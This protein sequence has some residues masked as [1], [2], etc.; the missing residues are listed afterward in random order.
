MRPLPLLLLPAALALASAGH[1]GSFTPPSG[2]TGWMTVQARACRVSNYYKC[3]GD[4]PGDQWRADFDQE[5]LFFASKIDR[6][7]QWVLSIDMNPM[8]RQT[9]DPGAAD[10]ASFDALLAGRDDFDFHLSRD[11]GTHSHV[12]GHD[13][14]TGRTVVIDHVPLQETEFSFRE[15]NEAGT[16]LRQSRGHEYVSAEWRTFFSGPSEWDDASGGGLCATRR[17]AHGVHLSGRAGLHE[18]AARVRVRRGAERG[19]RGPKPRRARR[20]APA[21]RGR[22]M[23]GGAAEGRCLCGAVRVRVARLASTMSACHCDMCRRWS[24]GGDDGG[25]RGCGGRGGERAGQGLRLLPL[26]GTGVVRRLRLGAL[27]PAHGARRRGPMS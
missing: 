23:S 22:A 19:A 1:A 6:Q 9:L 25:R 2:C 12:T 13:A 18:H 7:T 8:V 21:G 26:R 20:G 4:A 27:V 16:L 11:D 10:P 14:L 5:G 15:T 24:G 3:E 17:L